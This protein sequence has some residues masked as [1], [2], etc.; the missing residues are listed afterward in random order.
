[1]G[2]HCIATTLDLMVEKSAYALITAHNLVMSTKSEMVVVTP[3]KLT[4]LL[5]LLILFAILTLISLQWDGP[6]K[7]ILQLL[8]M[9]KKPL[10]TLPSF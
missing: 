7:R 10:T 1:M 4:T 3:H 2:Y 9:S 6:Q 8:T 5:T